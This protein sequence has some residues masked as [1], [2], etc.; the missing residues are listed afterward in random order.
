MH[1]A[2]LYI[3][4]HYVLSTI[5]LVQAIQH[6]TYSF[7]QFRK[8]SKKFTG[9]WNV[10][11][12]QSWFIFPKLCTKSAG[13]TR[14]FSRGTSMSKPLPVGPRPVVFFV[15]RAG[16][17][18]SEWW[19]G[20]GSVKKYGCRSAW[21]GN[22]K[23]QFVVE[24][25]PLFTA[26]GMYTCMGSVNHLIFQQVY[27]TDIRQHLGEHW[28]GATEPLSACP[29]QAGLPGNLPAGHVKLSRESKWLHTT[30]FRAII[31]RQLP[32][33]VHSKGKMAH[34]EERNPGK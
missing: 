29:R 24:V 2:S 25:M 33:V 19:A 30:I 4:V 1:S 32:F 28:Q 11:Q 15:F 34:W 21:T 14:D 16:I 27:Y 8:V 26:L 5:L 31:T 3:T 20:N 22:I 13:L 12:A 7:M 18:S 9:W 17:G 23:K 10:V 6:V